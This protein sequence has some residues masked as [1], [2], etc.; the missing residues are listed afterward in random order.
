MTGPRFCSQAGSDGVG[1]V[2]SVMTVFGREGGAVVWGH[3]EGH[4]SSDSLDDRG[5]LRSSSG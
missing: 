4:R 5:G 2:W 3:V 1:M